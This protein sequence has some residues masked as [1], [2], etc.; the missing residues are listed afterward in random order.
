MANDFV[1]TITTATGTTY[2][3]Q[4]ARLTVTAA[5]AGKVVSVDSNG[6]LSLTT[7]SGGTKLYQ[8]NLTGKLY[9]RTEA[10]IGTFNIKAVTKYSNTVSGSFYSLINNQQLLFLL[11]GNNILKINGVWY[12][13]IS[14]PDLDHVLV[15]SSSNGLEVMQTNDESAAGKIRFMI[16]NNDTVIEL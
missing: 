4:D 16:I 3:L 1:K 6:N 2:D 12:Y 5:D 11:E 8:H 10:E 13:I 9:D 7:P 14:F 15:N